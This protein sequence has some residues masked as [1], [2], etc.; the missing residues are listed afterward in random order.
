M[1][2]WVTGSQD[3]DD[4]M[5]LARSI[6]LAIQEISKDDSLIS[7]MH[8]DRPGA[9]QMTGSY[10]AKTKSF[11]TGKGFKVVEFI[12]PKNLSLEEKIEK[13]LVQSPEILMVFNK[14]ADSKTRKIRESAQSN[15][16]RIIEYK[17]S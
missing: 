5:T 16:I 11:L 14:G 17:N 4:D 10:I 7:F 6:T 8:F 12:P 13:I 15:K 9:E 3:W 1:K 2:L